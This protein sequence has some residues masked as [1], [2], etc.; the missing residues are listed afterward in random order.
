M[1]EDIHK[2]QIEIISLIE[3]NKV[4]FNRIKSLTQEINNS[5]FKDSCHK[6]YLS[7]CEP[8]YCSFRIT[9]TCK[10]FENLESLQKIV[11]EYNIKLF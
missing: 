10:Y 8:E 4:V 2:K 3:E 11:N 5:I 1:N 9:G 7:N 6:E